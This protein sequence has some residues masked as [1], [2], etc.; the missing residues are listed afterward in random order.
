MSKLDYETICMQVTSEHDK[1]SKYDT[2]SEDEKIML[3]EWISK[4]IQPA[5]TVDNYSSYGLKHDFEHETGVYVD[6]GQFKGAMLIVGYIP[7]YEVN[8]HTWTFKINPTYDRRDAPR[9]LA[10]EIA[11]YAHKYRTTLL[12]MYAPGH[13]AYRD[14]NR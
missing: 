10:S 11:A 14:Y 4:A 8:A 12:G 7:A 6:N 1:P 3:A 9:R 2:L 13:I 5:T